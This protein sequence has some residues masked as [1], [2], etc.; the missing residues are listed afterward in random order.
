MLQRSLLARRIFLKA[1]S[2]SAMPWRFFEAG[3]ALPGKTQ[4]ILYNP[5]CSGISRNLKEFRS[6]AIRMGGHEPGAL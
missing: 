3:D 5:T 2:W 6:G 1:A 4:E